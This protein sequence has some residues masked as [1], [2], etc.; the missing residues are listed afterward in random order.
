MS[1]L[2]SELTNLVAALGGVLRAALL[3]LRPFVPLLAWAAFWYFAVDWVRLRATLRAGGLVPVIVLLVVAVAVAVAVDPVASRQFGP[4]PVSSL[5]H[6]IGWA[7]AMSAVALLA[8]AAQI[9]RRSA[10]PGIRGVVGG[11]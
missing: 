9:S 11:D 4:V 10:P 8:G 1:E 6:K 3:V 5:V 7:A 2:L